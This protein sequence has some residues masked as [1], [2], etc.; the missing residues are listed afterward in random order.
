MKLEIRSRGLRMNEEMR[1]YIDDALAYSLGWFQRRIGEVT[2]Y[3]AD[4]KNPYSGLRC[5]I[6]VRVPR[7]GRI[8]VSEEHPEFY[9]LVDRAAQRASYAAQRH[10][11][12][13][14]T[15]RLR[16]GRRRIAAAA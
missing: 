7:S 11:E 3:I 9:T 1:A 2:V 6:V 15:R 10:F 12:R 14:M 16:H 13:R 4:R 8:V 5:H